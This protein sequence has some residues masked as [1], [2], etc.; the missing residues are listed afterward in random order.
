[1]ADNNSSS[2]AREAGTETEAQ[3]RRRLRQE[4]IMK[5]GG[6]RL[7]R[8]KGTLNKVQEENSD[9]EMAMAMAGGHELKTATERSPSISERSIV[10]G[11]MGEESSARRQRRVGNLARKARLDAD[12][13]SDVRSS[14]GDSG[15]GTARERRRQQTRAAMQGADIDSDALHDTVDAAIADPANELPQFLP[16]AASTGALAAS[17]ASDEG[18]SRV[19]EQRRFSAIGLWRTVAR[20]VPIASIY[21]YGLRREARHEQLMGDSETE[22][23]AK[24]SGLMDARPDKRL[25][26]WAGGS[27]L[28]WFAIVLE[29]ALFVAYAALSGGRRVPSSAL[30]R[31]PGV[32][33]WAAD[34]V[35]VGNR[36]VDS[37]SILLFFTVLSILSTA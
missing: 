35:S 36:I 1:M 27:H 6:D 11:D 8:I 37:M 18:G 34:A 30:A 13:G 4:R 7:N 3:K 20:M 32:P 28:L 12:D 22:V 19:L 23:H 2:T 5:R 15:S 21:L 9:G 25:D 17:F 33:A 10:E 26:E 29:L 14:G 24:W 16:S 31:I